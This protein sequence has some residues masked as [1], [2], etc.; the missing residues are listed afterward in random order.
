MTVAVNV[1]APAVEGVPERTPAPDSESPTGNEPAVTA[2][3]YDV[4]PVAA[5]VVEYATRVAPEGTVTVV[6]ASWGLTV[7][8]SDFVVFD[9][10]AITLTVKVLVPA[11]VGTPVSV[12]SECKLRPAGSEPLSKLHVRAPTPPVACTIS[13]YAASTSP[14]SSALVVIVSAG[15]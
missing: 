1:D 9:T 14:S 15:V 13:V 5:N 6:I 2:H 10:P 3:V 4:P 11:V 7:T 8:V 12:P